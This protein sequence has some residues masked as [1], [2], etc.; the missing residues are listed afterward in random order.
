M[1]VPGLHAD[2]L[3]PGLGRGARP[4]RLT[5]PSG[6]PD[7]HQVGGLT[8]S[9]T[10]V[11]QALTVPSGGQPRG[12]SHHPHHGSVRF[13]L[14]HENLPYTRHERTSALLPWHIFQTREQCCCLP[15][16]GDPKMYSC[17]SAFLLHMTKAE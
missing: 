7:V 3:C 15:E 8:T 11:Q 12:A 13:L 1:H 17:Q 10:E 6:E 5:G 4:P 16:D 9:A 2:L 14:S